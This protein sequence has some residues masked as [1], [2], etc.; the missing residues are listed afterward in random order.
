VLGQQVRVFLGVTVKQPLRIMAVAVAV[1]V[2][3]V[4]HKQVEQVKLQPYLALQ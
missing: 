1:L 4:L 3:L 2:E